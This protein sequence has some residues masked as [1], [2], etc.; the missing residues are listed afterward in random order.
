MVGGGGRAVAGQW[1]W[2]VAPGVGGGGVGG[3][4]DSGG[5]GRGGGGD[6]GWQAAVAVAVVAGAVVSR[7][8]CFCLVTAVTLARA[9][10]QATGSHKLSSLHR[11]SGSLGTGNLA[12]IK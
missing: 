1:S 6:G 2:L 12:Q 4:V 9:R 8:D 11:L 10:L 3:A 5:G 7:L